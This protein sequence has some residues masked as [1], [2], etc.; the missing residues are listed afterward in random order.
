MIGFI[1]FAAL[2]S[3]PT[4]I[5]VHHAGIAG[6]V[7]K[8]L[9]NWHKVLEVLGIDQNSEEVLGTIDPDLKEKLLAPWDKDKINQALPGNAD[10]MKEKT[11]EVV[12]SLFYEKEDGKFTQKLLERYDAPGALYEESEVN[13]IEDLIR[14]A[15]FTDGYS[16][17]VGRCA[18]T[19]S[20]YSLQSLVFFLVAAE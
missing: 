20:P 6:K 5:D 17:K 13:R 18:A 1:I 14:Q 10:E 2:L 8:G 19:F 11:L 16:D 7:Y 12:K 3:I 9:Q 4:I 15:K